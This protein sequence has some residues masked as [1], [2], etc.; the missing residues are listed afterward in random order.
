MIS[1][2]NWKYPETIWKYKS[3]KWLEAYVQVVQRESGFKLRQ[4]YCH[5]PSGL[6]TTTFQFLC[7]LSVRWKL[8]PKFHTTFS[9][10]VSIYIFC[11]KHSQKLSF[12]ILFTNL[13]ATMTW[14]SY[15]FHKSVKI[16]FISPYSLSYNCH[17]YLPCMVHLCR[18][19]FLLVHCHLHVLTNCL[20]L[21]H[22]PSLPLPLLASPSHNPSDWSDGRAPQP[23]HSN[24]G[25]AWPQPGNPALPTYSPAV[26]APIKNRSMQS[27]CDWSIKKLCPTSP[28]VF[29]PLHYN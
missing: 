4:H 10:C 6:T 7:F 18:N 25:R 11:W 27:S 17:S 19:S 26:I 24:S 5:M 1:Y 9:K 21:S 28:D 23:S 22:S 12:W 3:N 13:N 20:L 2:N 29:G 16:D 8:F 15:C 14:G